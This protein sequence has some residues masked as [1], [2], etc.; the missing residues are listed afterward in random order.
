MKLFAGI[1]SCDFDKMNQMTEQ[2]G[3]V[4]ETIHDFFIKSST[5]P[6]ATSASLSFTDIDR[7]LEEMSR[8]GTEK[9]QSK[10]IQGVLLDMTAV[11]LKYLIRLIKK[12]LKTAAGVKPVMEALS[13]DAYAAFQVST[14]CLFTK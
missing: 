13:A 3:D 14:H 9:H 10:V 12:D 6:P 5:R 8:D 1:F 2:N 7:C 11:E 4:S